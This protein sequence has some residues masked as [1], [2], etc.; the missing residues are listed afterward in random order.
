[1]F[2]IPF[3]RRNSRKDT[4]GKS[5][6]KPRPRAPGLRHLLLEPLEDRTLLDANY[7][8]VGA[9]LSNIFTALQNDGLK[10]HLWSPPAGF[11]LPIVGTQLK[12]GAGEFLTAF[13]TDLTN[14]LYGQKIN[15]FADFQNALQALDMAQQLSATV[16]QTPSAAAG[17]DADK[18]TI[19]SQPVALSSLN[20]ETGLP[21]LDQ[22]NNN[23]L[24][25]LLQQ[26][27]HTLKINSNISLTYSAT[28]YFDVDSQG[29]VTLDTTQNGATP[30]VSVAFSASFSNAS[31]PGLTLV[32]TSNGNIAVDL[33]ANGNL[34]FYAALS[35]ANPATYA[36]VQT[37]APTL[38][39]DL[40]LGPNPQN[41]AP[42]QASYDLKLTVNAPAPGNTIY[43][44][45]LF[46][47]LSVNW[48]LAG[49]N[50]LDSRQNSPV[51]TTTIQVGIASQSTLVSTWLNP[52]FDGIKKQLS[53]LKPTVDTLESVLETKI[54]ILGD[55]LPDYATLELILQNGLGVNIA[56]LSQFLGAVD[57]ILNWADP[58]FTI[59]GSDSL[60]LATYTLSSASNTAQDPRK[61]NFN[62]QAAL[63][64][65]QVTPGDNGQSEAQN[66]QSQINQTLGATSPAGT[67]D[68]PLL[69]DPLKDLKA[70]LFGDDVVLAQ[71]HLPQLA[72]LK[73]STTIGPFPIVPPLTLS[74]GLKFGVEG[75]LTFGYDTYGLSPKWNSQDDVTV[76]SPQQQQPPYADPVSEGIFLESQGTYLDLTG[77]ITLTLAADLGLVQ[78][79]G[80]GTLQLKFGIL[81]LNTGNLMPTSPLPTGT[82]HP[83]H[84]VPFNGSKED[85]LQYGDLNYDRQNGGPLC[86]FDIGGTISIG[87]E[88]YITVGVGPFSFTVDVS[89]GSITLAD[90]T[91]NTCS[92]PPNIQLAEA[93]DSSGQALM[94]PNTYSDQPLIGDLSGLPAIN[95]TWPGSLN[96]IGTLLQKAND[97]SY[98]VTKQQFLLLDLGQF[99]KD[100]Q[101]DGYNANQSSETFEV[102]PTK[103]QGLQVSAYGLS[104]TFPGMN[105]HDT[106][107][108]AFGG[109]GSGGLPENITVDS[110]IDANV[111]LF[112]GANVSEFNYEGDGDAYLAGGTYD[113]MAQ[114]PGDIYH[115][116]TFNTLVG[117]SGHNYLLGGELNP[118][119]PNGGGVDVYDYLSYPASWNVLRGGANGSNILQAGTAGATLRAGDQNGDVLRGSTDPKASN[120]TVVMVAGGGNDTMYG[121]PSSANV[122]QW[123]EKTTKHDL[124]IYGSGRSGYNSQGVPLDELDVEG[125]Q[126]FET[127]TVSG[128]APTQPGTAEEGHGPGVFIGGT[129]QSKNVLGNIMAYTVEKVGVDAND[130]NYTGGENYIVNEPPN[131]SLIKNAAFYDLT[132]TGITQL[133]LNFHQWEVQN[134]KAVNDPAQDDQL[135][136]YPTLGATIGTDPTTGEPVYQDAYTNISLLSGMAPTWSQPRFILST[137]LT[138]NTDLLQVYT[139]EKGDFFTVVGT[140]PNQTYIS[141]AGDDTINVGGFLPNSGGNNQNLFGELGL[142]AIEGPLVVDAGAGHNR[143]TFD[144]QRAVVNPSTG[145]EAIT[146]TSNLAAATDPGLQEALL[147]SISQGLSGALGYVLRYHGTFV[148]A[149]P[150]SA[151]GGGASAHYRY[152]I[153]ITFLAS[154]G[155]Y[156]LTTNGQ[157]GVIY[158]GSGS[159]V[160][161]LIYVAS[162]QPNFLTEI[163]TDGSSSG[164]FVGFDGGRNN[165]VSDP[166][167]TLQFIEATL[168]IVGA[169]PTANALGSGA[170][171]D[172]VGTNA[173]ESYVLLQTAMGD[174]EVREVNGNLVDIILT[175]VPFAILMAPD[176]NNDFSVHGTA[177][178]TFTTIDTGNGDNT[179]SA[180]QLNLAINPPLS[181]LDGIQ[182]PV[183]IRGGKGTNKLFIDDDGGPNGQT[184]TLGPASLG[185]S[186]GIQ[187]G[188]ESM[189]SVTLDVASYS[190]AVNVILI[191]GTHLHTA[192]V[193]NT[194]S[195][196]NTIALNDPQVG[197]DAFLGTLDLTQEAGANDSVTANDSSSSTLAATEKYDLSVIGPPNYIFPAGTLQRSG[198]ARIEY[199]LPMNLLLEVRT[200][201]KNTVDVEATVPPSLLTIQ[202]GGLSDD[203][204]VG[205]PQQQT[206]DSIAGNLF[207]NGGS[208]TSVTL[209]DQGAGKTR[210]Y[211]FYT[212]GQNGYSYFQLDNQVGLIQWKQLT[213]LVLNASQFNTKAQTAGNN[214]AVE[215]TA[216]GTHVTINAGTGDSIQVGAGGPTDSLLA[217]QGRLDVVG[218]GAN[219]SLDLD[220]VNGPIKNTFTLTANEL[221]SSFEVPIGY[222]NIA[223]LFLMGT[224]GDSYVIQGTPAGTNVD[225]VGNGILNKLIGPSGTNTWQFQLVG[226]FVQYTLNAD[227]S[228]S[229]IGNLQGGSGTNTF[230][231]IGTGFAGSIAGG[232]GT[233]TLD[234]GAYGSSNVVVDLQTGSA[235]G[236][237]NGVS[238]IQDVIGDNG[239]G[240]SG[241]YNLLIGAG[242]NTLKGGTGRRNIL[243]AGKSASTLDGGDQ[244][245]LLIAGYTNYDTQA[246]L[247]S[248]LQI[249]AYWAG[250]DPFATRVTKLEAGAGVPALNATTVFGNGGSNTLVGKGELAL[251][252]TDNKDHIS[253]FN[254]KVQEVTITP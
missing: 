61:P 89:F 58:S 246:G 186:G 209:L 173:A 15:T 47:D 162:V 239:G 135:E 151:E 46:T 38:A 164:V 145:G 180:G 155:D 74:L 205:A 41:N 217:L 174:E 59:T 128:I 208:A 111:A 80:G 245:D 139:T 115:T 168:T 28:V 88:A 182:G 27:E 63:A 236:V 216:L 201:T 142:D 91:L 92:P 223:T 166:D 250:A 19:T 178:G 77:G 192:V 66:L 248:W 120:S 101:A 233:N 106:T 98:D 32:S 171:L 37:T 226:Q 228:F 230:K 183:V 134:Q 25:P 102:S 45:N 204:E 16:S 75:D 109:T 232:S 222:K 196:T 43:F 199:Q 163:E 254:A 212:G 103:N 211:A 127:W 154:G 34:T 129:D 110:G 231:F 249:A 48:P 22:P 96:A 8:N 60:A 198:L 33:T 150:P 108:L 40:T 206:L 68:L 131:P 185:R 175:T 54:P 176:Q 123:G 161:S 200:G 51:P 214:I 62:L 136:V 235:T 187:I 79:G 50:P 125:D 72:G 210:T 190:A 42:L 167:S 6:R 237:V 130:S 207:I 165:A 5:S 147:G 224:G 177:L 140:Q 87:L 221:D 144:E 220:D 97:P 247:T 4:A 39:T 3:A 82:V 93:F 203:I 113:G 85:V 49:Q 114:V 124:T 189:T 126:G 116:T 195:G 179:I 218:K 146:L 156:A 53:F 202:G 104:Q 10:A 149:P 215:G 184:Y 11:S 252:F 57:G 188:F 2:R 71:Y 240:S 36:D 81:G 56:P 119:V 148:P 229:G 70:L 122:Y 112:G 83:F 137:A 244:D 35:D 132:Q 100:V 225:I 169:P 152:P 64:N 24:A 191:T 118:N 7:M 251:I 158:K 67:L 23:N 30:L 21:G 243:V 78:V 86:A 90:F 238:G 157:Q 105:S 219:V 234:Y 181:N 55:L 9:G 253:G 213:A 227:V 1:M 52:F 172:D 143:I 73:G 193:V 12:S 241:M 14:E 170:L 65:A 194:G 121:S 133:N 18:L 26:V 69:T 107:I 31:V 138:K 76:P 17:T 84:E 13:A 242:G 44:P 99:D 20:F 29:N 117:G 95:S 94:P 153:G 141:G 197:M 159:T 160:G